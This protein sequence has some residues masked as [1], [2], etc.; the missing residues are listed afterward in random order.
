MSTER[1]GIYIDLFGYDQAASKM[2]ALQGKLKGLNGHRQ[3]IKVQA[4]I[5]SLTLNKSALRSHKVKLEADMAQVDS[6][7]KK[8]K[9][10]YQDLQRTM[11][12]PLAKKGLYDPKAYRDLFKLRSEIS[13]LNKQKIDI[14]ANLGQVNAEI[15]QTTSAINQLKTAMAGIK[16]ASLGQIWSKN[17]ARFAHVGQ[18]MQSAGNAITRMA[19]PIRNMG[20]MLGLGAGFAAFNKA[21]EGIQSGFSRYDTMKKY[22][23]MMAEYNTASFNA[24][25]S[26]ER[27]DK[28]VRGLPTG[29]D[30]IVDL[31]QRFTLSLGDMEKGTNLAIA[32]NNAF[33]ASMT[34][35]SQRY[36]GMLQLQDLMNGKKLNSREW[37][38]LG[39]SMGKAINEIGKELGYSTDQ[40]GEFRQAL[41]GGKIDTQTFLKALEKV[42]TGEGSIAKMA[43][44]SKQTWEAFSANI[45]N[46][47]SRMTAGVIESLD[48]ITQVATGKN[49][50]TLLADIVPTKIDN[51]TKS[52]KNWVRANP[53]VITDFVDSL[54]G[55]NWGSIA[56]G[57]ADGI[58]TIANGISTAAKVVGGK[59]LAWLGKMG[60][61]LMPLGTFL[62]IAGGLLKG[63][64]HI[65]AW[66]PTLGVGIGRL[67]AGL[68]EG[69]KIGGLAAFGTK[70]ADLIKGLKL[71]GKVEAAT[72]AAEAAGKVAAS[73]AVN[74]KNYAKTIGKGLIGLGG[75]LA[76]VLAI[77]GTVALSVKM[78]K[79]IVKDLGTISTDMGNVDPDA[80]K[81]LGAWIIGIG[82][83]F[84]ALGVIAGSSVNSMIIAAQIEAGLLAVGIILTTI[85]GFA[86]VNT[87]LISGTVR[88]LANAVQGVADI[89][90][91]INDLNNITVNA[92]GLNRVAKSIASAME[93]LD[94]LQS[95]DRDSGT[96]FGNVAAK[97][98]KKK[99]DNIG[100]IIGTLK[101]SA[102]DMKAISEVDSYAIEQA[103]NTVSNL[104][105]KLDEVYAQIKEDFDVSTKSDVKGSERG[106]GIVDNIKSIVS[107]IKASLSDLSA[108]ASDNTDYRVAIGKV[109]SMISQM[110][111]LSDDFN[112]L[113]AEQAPDSKGITAKTGKMGQNARTGISQSDVSSS[114]MQSDWV[115]NIK[116]VMEQMKGVYDAVSAKGGM[117]DVDVTVFSTMLNRVKSILSQLSRSWSEWKIYFNA[118]KNAEADAAN[119]KGVE[120]A[121]NSIKSMMGTLASIGTGLSK[122][123]YGQSTGELMPDFSGSLG[124]LKGGSPTSLIDTAIENITKMITGLQEIANAITQIPDIANLDGNMEQVKS[125]VTKVQSIMSTLSSLGEGSLASTD[126][127][128]FTA[129]N[130]IKLLISRLGQALNTEALA[131]LQAQVDSF[132][133]Q[134]EQIFKTLNSDFSNVEVTVK[135]NG[136]V[137]GDKALI[138]RIN[139]AAAGIKRA[140]GRIQTSYTKVITVN[141]VGRV[142]RSG[143]FGGL[144]PHTGGYVTPNR[145]LYKSKGGGIGNLFKPKGT[146]TVPAMLTPGEYVQKKAAVD[147]WGIDFMRKVNHMDVRGVIRSVN[148]RARGVMSSARSTI[149]TNNITNNYNNNNTQHINTS[150]PNFAYRRAN[151][152]LGMI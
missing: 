3:K 141:L 29:L 8:T 68:G 128:A 44:L 77:G 102:L 113:F 15:K 110:K 24:S 38:S 122:G 73:K 135:I 139:S 16:T 152:A 32:A 50:N 145:L 99:F 17:A 10:A 134:V 20:R 61:Y 40:M 98:L 97:K 9:T 125:A 100:S 62:T 132:R 129:I 90:T 107:S 56:K 39:S 11:N 37:M 144:T 85:S 121:I 92:S 79:G 14:K 41:Y 146:D 18:A 27:L 103:G 63:G 96:W 28:A 137:E 91:G 147:F 67:I 150:N 54:R 7:L 82:S 51:V 126:G 130:N 138:A 127:A 33:L 149:I 76:G 21:S 104:V 89:A 47:F 115:T 87:K 2:E 35:E 71:F 120:T 117:Q 42:G 111:T 116:A 119:M 80:M 124:G 112:S 136:K 108:I 64:R 70:I 5:D 13:S 26:I 83:A 109:K 106:L 34:T 151:R 95:G 12:A 74:L 55:V 93:Q 140:V 66:L 101:Q 46:A 19:A 143:N 25:Q 133:S 148:A 49:L 69:L 53:K 105:A 60:A 88:N 59:N 78:I 1:V 75:A 94:K 86:W 30:E 118:F 23:K 31:S 36:Q 22:P 123:D 43:E 48:E 131:G 58:L 4:E 65:F 6:A 114:K 81:K 45:R 142:N 52:I 72:T 84:T 57:F